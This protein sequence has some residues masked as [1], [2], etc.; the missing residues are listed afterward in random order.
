MCSMGRKTI[1]LSKTLPCNCNSLWHTLYKYLM[2]VDIGLVLTMPRILY[3]LSQTCKHPVLHFSLA[4][5]LV[6]RRGGRHSPV[7]ETGVP[8]G[9]GHRSVRYCHCF[10]TLSGLHPG[11]N[12]IFLSKILFE[13]E[14]V[15]SWGFKEE[16][17]IGG[18]LV[19]ISLFDFCKGN[20]FK[21]RN[22]LLV[23]SPQQSMSSFLISKNR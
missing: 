16:W 15:F 19:Q 18:I 14:S 13:W 1:T 12:F 10:Q 17:G 3:L 2:H 9:L 11:E 6:E 4:A 8:L 5:H 7:F 20:S 22:T 23:Y 21:I